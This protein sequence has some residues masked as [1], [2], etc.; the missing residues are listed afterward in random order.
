MFDCTRTGFLSYNT[1]IES[2]LFVNNKSNLEI[3]NTN[4]TL[5]LIEMLSILLKL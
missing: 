5:L 2:T 1:R 3:C 4:N